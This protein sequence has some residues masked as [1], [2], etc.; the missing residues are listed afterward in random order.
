MVYGL[1]WVMTNVRAKRLMDKEADV[2][3]GWWPEDVMQ[4]RIFFA[5]WLLDFWRLL[6]TAVPGEDLEEGIWKNSIFKVFHT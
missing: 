5:V 2:Y 4:S 6:V 1:S 3:Q